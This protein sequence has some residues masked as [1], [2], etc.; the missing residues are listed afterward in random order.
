[1]TFDNSKTIIGL[2]IKLFGATVVLLAYVALTYAAKIIK[3]PI[4]GL[5]DTLVT[6]VLVGIYLFLAIL[7]MIL[8][9]QYVWFSDDDERIIFRYFTAGLIGGKKNSV[10]IHKSALAGF[11]T[12]SKY[13]GL[14]KS[15]TLFQKV[16]QGKAK[17]PP[18]YISALSQDQKDKILKSLLKYSQPVSN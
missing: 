3:F 11:K 8:N 4:L 7:P 5:S 6:L 18:I 14:S 2:R 12:D 16:G 1:M 15:L 13:F 10:E 9:Y 17:Y